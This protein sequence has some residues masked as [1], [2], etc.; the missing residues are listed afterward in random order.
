MPSS[1]FDTWREQ[2]EGRANKMAQDH[3]AEIRALFADSG[4]LNEAPPE[5]IDAATFRAEIAAFEQSVEAAASSNVQV[6]AMAKRKGWQAA[7]DDCDALL[8]DAFE[9]GKRRLSRQP[10]APWRRLESNEQWATALGQALNLPAD[11]VCQLRAQYTPDK[12]GPIA[13]H[14]AG[15]G[16]LINL[17]A[18]KAIEAHH[19]HDVQRQYVIALRAI[20]AE[21]WGRRLITD[22]TVLGQQLTANDTWAHYLGSELGL[23]NPSRID[24]PSEAVLAVAPTVLLGWPRWVGQYALDFAR[25]EDVLV[26]PVR[27][28]GQGVVEVLDNLGEAITETLRNE[29]QTLMA[30]VM[31]GLKTVLMIKGIR[32]SNAHRALTILR[33]LRP[34][35]DAIF[36]Q[37]FKRTFMDWLA[38]VLFAKLDAAIG[39]EN[40]PFAVQLACGK[41]YTLRGRTSNEVTQQ[42]NVNPELDVDLRLVLLSGLKDARHCSVPELAHAVR[43]EFGMDVPPELFEMG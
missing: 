1:D 15:T 18:L 40:V 3:A 16:T 11:Q 31:F 2:F 43:N 13:L 41:D 32:S 20:A 42:I 6:K 25:V 22:D 10:R 34:G 28:G 30:W 5:R 33:Q 14:V 7:L 35:L 17:A 29:A 26:A 39:P 12:H 4:L 27:F 21:R 36:N 8:S 24:D 37:L 9:V 38:E 23:E 19:P